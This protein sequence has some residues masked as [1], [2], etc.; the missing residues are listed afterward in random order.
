MV[1]PEPSNLDADQCIRG[2]YDDASGR[3]RVDAEISA[4]IITPPGLEVSIEDT[5]DSIKI[6]NGS[7]IYA[8]VTGSNALKVDGSGVVQP[9]TGSVI[10]SNFPA[11]QQVSQSGVWSVGRTWTLA[12]TTDSVNIGNFPVTQAVTQSGTWNINNI[13]GVVSLP[14]GAATSA[15]QTSGNTSLASIDS[16]LTSPL[17]VSQSGAWTTGRTWN[18]SNLTDS[19]NIG[20]FPSIQQ[21]SQSGS[22]TINGISTPISTGF[23]TRSDTFSS[24]GTGTTIDSSSAPVKLFSIQVDISGT[25]TAWDVRL[26]GSLDNLNFMQILQHTNT[27]GDGN[28]VFSGNSFSPCLYF[29]ARCA[30][31]TGLGGSSLTASILGCQ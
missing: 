23:Y 9:I 1:T 10:I 7:G 8:Q 18:L 22:W 21:V 20:N 12:N 13:S 11:V 16:K 31:L 25:V 17:A 6:G 26:E 2:A 28:I 30:G 29:R 4:S 19:V 24:T 3:L 15:L 5:D 27:T 14:T